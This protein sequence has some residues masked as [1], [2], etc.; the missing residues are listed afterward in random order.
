[1]TGIILLT[2]PGFGDDLVKSASHVLGKPLD[3]I[4]TVQIKPEYAPDEIRQQ[5]L[6]Q[7]EKLDDNGGVLVL[8]DIYGA[9]HWNVACQL[10]EKGQTE[11]V[12]GLNLPMLIRAIN[13]IDEHVG[14][15][16]EI[17]AKGGRDSI[18]IINTMDKCA[19]QK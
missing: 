19:P 18:R 3:N 8:C 7:I 6:D 11:M 10:V 5:I 12:S 13:Y 14:E 2:F 4:S 16:A 9:T 17:V 15:L 1:M